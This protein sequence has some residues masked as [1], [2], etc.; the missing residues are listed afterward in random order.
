M[1][2]S[3]SDSDL[4]L[5]VPGHLSGYHPDK[6]AERSAR[7]LAAVEAARAAA[8]GAGAGAERGALRLESVEW[9][10]IYG[11]GEGNSFCLGPAGAPATV[12]VTGKNA[13]GKTAF[14]DVVSLALFGR[15]SEGR[16][17]RGRPASMVGE[18]KPP[19][20]AA[21]AE[22][23][24]EVDGSRFRVRREFSRKKDG[25]LGRTAMVTSEGSGAIVAS[26]RAETD[27]WVAGF[28]TPGDFAI[29]DV[30]D[31]DLLCMAPADQKAFMDA[32]LK[33]G[34]TQ[35]RL[36]AVS[37]SQKAHAWLGRALVASAEDSTC[38]DDPSDEAL[39]GAMYDSKRAAAD[40]CVLRAKLAFANIASAVFRDR[41]NLAKRLREA[42]GPVLPRDVGEAELSGLRQ[43]AADA[44]QA[45]RA[46]ESDMRASERASAAPPAPARAGE[47]VGYLQDKAA[48]YRRAVTAA[49]RLRAL[50]EPRAFNEGCWACAEREGGSV[51][52]R[53]EC[54]RELEVLG[55]SGTAE[56]V[57]KKARNYERRLLQAQ[58]R[59]DAEARAEEWAAAHGAAV[60]R[61][62]RAREAS[63]SA[64]RE[65]EKALLERDLHASGGDPAALA[66]AE[67]SGLADALRRR[68]AAARKRE[69]ESRVRSSALMALRRTANRQRARSAAYAEAGREMLDKAKALRL[70]HAQANQRFEDALCDAV[71][72]LAGETNAVLSSAYPSLSVRAEWHHRTSFVLWVSKGPGPGARLPVEKA[73]GFERSAVSLALKA[74][75]RKTGLASSTGWMLVDE[76]TAGFDDDNAALLPKMLRAI[77]DGTGS[78]VIALA[79][80]PV[81]GLDRECE[82]AGGRLVFTRAPP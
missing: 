67:D 76:A 59:C 81:H 18:D 57:A 48:K 26:G 39:S 61:A 44:A 15:E 19:G 79:Q 49:E 77:A 65:L 11:F 8:G 51:R 36:D 25:K 27:A 12:A 37:E 68:L 47:S 50:G 64:S 54:A 63:E 66:C 45:R 80:R 13:S 55:V 20:A 7:V 41:R 72:R 4:L 14:V 43:R 35:A 5:G 3:L 21:W 10:W 33:T 62:A 31:K 71:E 53:L 6:V 42:A 9:Q 58:E 23:S 69:A 38:P 17:S 73:S 52:A 60:A 24:V 2:G 16:E 75:L 1:I 29:A 32:A 82:I 74:A 34:R 40:T 46:A 70:A 56:E 30:R 22:A 28:V 78:H